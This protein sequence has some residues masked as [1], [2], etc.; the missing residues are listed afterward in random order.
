VKNIF[1]F[2]NVPQV[3]RLNFIKSKILI[4]CLFTKYVPI[5]SLAML[6]LAMLILK[7]S[8]D[9]YYSCAYSL[10]LLL[11]IVLHLLLQGLAVHVHVLVQDVVDD[12][13]DGLLGP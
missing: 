2:V 13:K 3:N 5:T 4:C 8:D 1:I 10:L 11:P 9:Y 12:T 7:P 6:I